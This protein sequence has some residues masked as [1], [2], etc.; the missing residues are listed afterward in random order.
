MTGFR[1]N[2]HRSYKFAEALVFNGNDVIKLID[3][4]L[5]II[6]VKHKVLEEQTA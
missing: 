5:E 2:Q 6:K 1:R 4:D 3:E